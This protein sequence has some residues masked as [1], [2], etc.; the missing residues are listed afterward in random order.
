MR[1]LLSTW[2][3][4][5]NVSVTLQNRVD[6]VQQVRGE[7]CLKGTNS[8]GL[9]GPNSW[10][11]FKLWPYKGKS[12]DDLEQLAKRNGLKVQLWDFPYLQ[13]PQGS[14]DAVNESITR[15]NP[16]DIWLDVE[17]SWAKNYPG[18]TGPFLRGLGVV[19]ARYWLQSYRR[20]D[21]HPEIKWDKWLSY[22]DPNGDY[23]IHGLGPQAYPIGAS[24]WALD[25][26]RMVDE[27]E[28]ILKRVGRPDMPWLPTLPTFTERGW[29]P[30]F[31]Q[32][33]DGIDYLT[34]RLGSRLKG[35]NFW[36]QD[37]LFNDQ[38]ASILSYIGTLASDEPEPP[39]PPSPGTP[40]LVRVK[41]TSVPF[42]NIRKEPNATSQDIGDLMPGS[43]VP[44]VAQEGDWLQLAG[45]WI[46]KDY[47][48]DA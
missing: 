39:E 8:T 24:S 21:L 46:H 17:G 42:L 27:Y 9:Y 12:N 7:F 25:F 44:V 28:T 33:M 2:K 3:P 35:F 14:A 1:V 18:N 45:G 29:T 19:R 26:A 11:L 4:W 47:V 37:F 31:A 16:S 23:I 6:Q 15:W 10:N 22:K 13:Y 20:P 48:E 38:F 41:S 36:R 32:M 40:D 34:N 5:T 30:N 43:I